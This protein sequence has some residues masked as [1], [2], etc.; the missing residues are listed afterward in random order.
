M[1]KRSPTICPIVFSLDAFGDTWSLVI[2]RDILLFNK[3]H[4][5]E[6]LGSKEKIASNILSARLE[7]LVENGLLTKEADTANKSA[8]IYRPTQKALELLPMVIAMMQWGAKYNPDTNRDSGPV[9]R[10]LLTDPEGLR[11]R[12]IE[13]FP[14]VPTSHSAVGAPDV[15]EAA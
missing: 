8:A 4:F 11:R 5:R 6:F 7:S 13:R 3:S 12:I 9:M 15:G 1:K 14:E 10:T 2:L